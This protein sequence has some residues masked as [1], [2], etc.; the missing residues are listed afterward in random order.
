MGNYVSCVSSKVPSNVVKVI[1]LYGSVQEFGSAMKAADLMLDNPQ[2][3]VCHSSALQTGRRISALSADE[4]LE[5]GHLYFLLPMRKLNHSLSPS[6]MASLPFKADSALQNSSSNY[7]SLNRMLPVLTHLCQFTGDRK[8]T[9]MSGGDELNEAIGGA[10]RTAEP[11]HIFSTELQVEDAD[12][13]G[14]S[15]MRIVRVK[16]WK[17]AL[18]TISESPTPVKR[19]IDVI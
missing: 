13:V 1:T 16:S 5:L 3:F 12:A 9:A 11:K 17:P 6:D 14:E 4:E 18:E 8:L 7:R 15:S 19:R 10:K 2:H